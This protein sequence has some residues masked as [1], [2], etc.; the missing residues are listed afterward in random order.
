MEQMQQ[1]LFS[2]WLDLHAQCTCTQKTLGVLN[3]HTRVCFFDVPKFNPFY[4]V[5]NEM[6][7]IPCVLLKHCVETS[8]I[9][10]IKHTMCVKHFG[11]NDYYI[12]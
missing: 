2:S 12:A 4:N 8:I 7:V 9:M 5:L 1:L 11:L 6:H 3:L 10:F